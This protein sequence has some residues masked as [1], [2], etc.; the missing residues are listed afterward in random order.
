MAITKASIRRFQTKID[1]LTYKLTES[2]PNNAYRKQEV[3]KSDLEGS[4][5]INFGRAGFFSNFFEVLG[6][7]G[8]CEREKYTPIAYGGRYCNDSYRRN[9]YWSDSGYNGVYN[10]WEYFFE[11]LSR[12]PVDCLLYPD[13]FSRN[14]R[15]HIFAPDGSG[16]GLIKTITTETIAR[17]ENERRRELEIAPVEITDDLESFAHSMGYAKVWRMLAYQRDYP[18]VQYRKAVNKIICK[19]VKLKLSVRSQIDQFYEEHMVGK[20]VVGLHVRRTDNVGSEHLGVDLDQYCQIVDTYSSKCLIYVATDSNKV[21][22][23]LKQRYGKRI[24]YSKCVR[25]NSSKPVHNNHDKRI[26]SGNPQLGEQV[27]TDALL[28]SKTRFFV[29]GLSG[30]A[31]A[32]LFF[33][34]ELA[35]RSV[36]DVFSQDSN[37]RSIS[38]YSF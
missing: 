10:V 1:A 7:V 20:N 19:Y 2:L 35:H 34:P 36:W 31:S 12:K 3:L 14:T 18:S 9:M 38:A 22:N 33:N 16:I 23:Q 15:E 4:Y 37:L 13:N 5:V 24:L 17:V 26:T 25:S 8:W 27:L 28:L 29:H 32:A 11:P 30:V 21:L 6:Y